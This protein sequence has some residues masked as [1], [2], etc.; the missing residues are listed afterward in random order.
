MS[1]TLDAQYP[2][3]VAEKGYGTVHITV[4]PATTSTGDANPSIT[5]FSGGYFGSQIP[6]D[7]QVEIVHASAG[8]EALVKAREVKQEGMHYSHKWQG[9]TLTITAHG[10]SAHSSVPENGVNAIS[11]LADA[12]NVGPW[13][14]NTAGNTVNLINDMLGTNA[15]GEKFGRIA[16]S[17]NF[18]GK[19][20][21]VPTVVQDTPQGTDININ[22]RRPRGKS[23]KQ[24]RAEIL[25]A[26]HGWE[27]LHGRLGPV[28]VD[29]RDAWV[30]ADAPQLPVLL[31]VFSHFTG[32]ARS[33]P[34]SIGGA[35]NSRFFPRAV[36]FGP[37]MPGAVYT[38]HS[39]HEFLSLNQLLLDLQMYTAVIVELEQ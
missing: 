19:M 21:F 38:G 1:I 3:V 29:L 34:V 18:M 22:V 31:S 2:A 12:L 37:A 20:V 36:S 7:A 26:L 32:D 13:P 17:D 16:Y 28:T 6:E 11:M 5:R 10:K 4:P 15:Y 8:L 33:R 24:L 27:Q 35:T 23:E 30:Q 39:E 14:G 9:E 25:D